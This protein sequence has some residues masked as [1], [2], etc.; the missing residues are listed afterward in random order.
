M[1]HPKGKIS[2]SY[3]KKKGILRA[4]ITLPE[5]MRGNFEYKG[6]SFAIKEGRNSLR[7][8]T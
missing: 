3:E 8:K 6:Q 1:P 4:E 2:V 5:G 7:I